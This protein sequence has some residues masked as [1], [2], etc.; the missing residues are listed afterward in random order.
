MKAHIGM[1]GNE[2]ADK[3]TKEAAH[4]EDDHNIVYN[5]IPATTVATEIDMKRL[6]KW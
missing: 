2:A 6:T 5:K 1:V 4:D 3:L